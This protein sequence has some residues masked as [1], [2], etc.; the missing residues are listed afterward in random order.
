MPSKVVALILLPLALPESSHLPTLFQCLIL[1]DI[2]ILAHP[3]GKKWYFL[4]T[5][6]SQGTEMC[7][8]HK[9]VNFVADLNEK[10]RTARQAHVFYLK[11]S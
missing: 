10:S 3:M 6:L 7:Y 4:L 1:S 5:Y 2:K 11:V 9:L 8:V